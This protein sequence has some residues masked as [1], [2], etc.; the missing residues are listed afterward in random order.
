MR[1]PISKHAPTAKSSASKSE[2]FF[3]FLRLPVLRHTSMNQTSYHSSARQRGTWKW[4]GDEKG[5]AA[6]TFSRKVSWAQRESLEISPQAKMPQMRFLKMRK[7]ANIFVG[8]IQRRFG[9]RTC[10]WRAG[11]MSPHLSV[12]LINLYF[13]SHILI[14]SAYLAWTKI[15]VMSFFFSFLNFS[16]CLLIALPWTSLIRHIVFLL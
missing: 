6:E 4:G 8:T 5:S 10:R 15:Q 13:A 2:Y 14:F 11:S 9:R 12:K 1:W 3:T 7:C 16:A